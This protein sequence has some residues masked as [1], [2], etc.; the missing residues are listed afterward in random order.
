MSKWDS[1]SI[2]SKRGVTSGRTETDRL[3]APEKDPKKDLSDKT[4]KI[5]KDNGYLGKH[6]QYNLNTYVCARVCV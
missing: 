6:Q 4:I 2:N 3:K 1:I 5:L